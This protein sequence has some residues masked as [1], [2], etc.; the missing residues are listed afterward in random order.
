MK[1]TKCTAIAIN[2]SRGVPTIKVSLFGEGIGVEASVPSG[3]STGEK[4]AIELRDLDGDGV[5]GAITHIEKT[6]APILL[7]RDWS[8]IREID[9]MLIDL[10]GTLNKAKLG[11]NTTLAVSIASAKLFAGI[12][13]IPFWKYISQESGQEPAR[14]SLYVNMIN[15]GMHAS[16]ENTSE[17]KTSQSLPFQEYIIVFN[18][19]TI[20]ES[21]ELAQNTLEKL[22]DILRKKGG[23]RVSLG[24][25]GGYSPSF[26]KAVDEPFVVLAELIKEK[27][28]LFIATDVAASS[29]F[30]NG[31]YEIFGKAYDSNQLIDI[32]KNLTKKLPLRS[33]EDPFDENDIKG[34]EDITKELG[35]DN[36]IVGDDLTVT[37]PKV[38]KEIGEIKASNAVIIK[39]N[40]IGTLTETFSAVS[41]ARSFGWKI[42]ASHRSGETDDTAIA[43]IAFGLGAYG[44]KAGAPSQYERRV[45][46]ERLLEIEQEFESIK[47]N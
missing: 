4:E 42:I 38:I 16:S 35:G 6:I 47:D 30:K 5:F 40:Q 7:S 2:D 23:S 27:K 11:A 29:F 14:P 1:I 24:D 33:I 41:A 39:P 8:N 45:K 3:K 20:K 28:G 18:K 9:D 43:D 46:Y 15:G 12:Q 26:F 17:T 34:F 13:N 10:D 37:N 31:S 21:Y 36:L 22:G 19:K 44:I 32:Y 25:E